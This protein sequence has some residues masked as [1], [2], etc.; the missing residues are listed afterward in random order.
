VGITTII[1]TH[2]QDDAFDLGDTVAVLREGR[3]EQVGAPETLYR[4]PATPFVGTFIGRASWLMGTTTGDGAVVVEGAR[5]RLDARTAREAGQ[6]VRL[7]VRPEALRLVPAGTPGL[8]V[9]ITD[10]RFAGSTTYYLATTAAGSVLEVSASPGA[11]TVGQ[12]ATLAP[13]ADPADRDSLVRCFSPE[14]L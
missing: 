1:V 9:T 12:P 10:R 5:W 4:E 11:A 14:S 2:E 6:R 8:A 3:L 7:L 13:V